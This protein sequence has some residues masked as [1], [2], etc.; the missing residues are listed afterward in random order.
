MSCL[1]WIVAAFSLGFWLAHYIETPL[2]R[3]TIAGWQ[4]CL[5]TAA[6]IH[7]ETVRFRGN[8]LV[9]VGKDKARKNIGGPEE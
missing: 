7:A 2:R 3:E 6:A 8:G 9:Y 4:E 1:G 5:N